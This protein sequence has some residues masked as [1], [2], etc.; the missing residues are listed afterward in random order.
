M[1]YFFVSIVI[2]II[3][4]AYFINLNSK[5]NIKN[6]ISKIIVIN[7]LKRA[8]RLK[9]FSENY[10]L[11][12][13]FEVFNAI[14]GKLLNFNKLVDNNIIGDI[15]IKSLN[16]KKRK[17]HYELTTLNAVGCYLSH[18]YLWKNILNLKENKFIIFEDDTLFNKINLNEINYRLS[19]LPK[20]WDIYLLS[21]PKCCYLKE[22]INKNLF[23]VKRFFLLNAYVINKKAINKI[24]KSNTIFPIN[25]QLDSYLSELAQDYNFNIY[26]HNNYNY[27]EQSQFFKTDIQ[28]NSNNLL[29]DRCFISYPSY[30]NKQNLSN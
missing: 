22:K 16:N 2:V 8:N 5:I 1:I 12:I 29:F 25:Q 10:N 13:P 24:L 6:N 23:K 19:I 15:G 4:I 7:L 21:N 9:K 27:Y 20:N 11:Q 26:V 17:Y 30:N 18:Y 28:D 3:C 14:D